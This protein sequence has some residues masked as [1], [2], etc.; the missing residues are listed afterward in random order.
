MNYIM[1]IGSRKSG[2]SVLFYLFRGFVKLKKK[3]IEKNSDWSDPT[4]SPA[5][6][7]KKKPI[8]VKKKIRVEA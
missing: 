6:P 5:Y 4:H 7:I 2:P 1:Y 3:K 8:T